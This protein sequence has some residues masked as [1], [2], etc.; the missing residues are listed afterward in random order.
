MPKY[1]E[2]YQG[3]V[4]QS[5]APAAVTRQVITNRASAAECCDQ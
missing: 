2:K 4:S 1:W 3:V 5:T